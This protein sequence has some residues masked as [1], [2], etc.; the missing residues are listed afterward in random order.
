M[1]RNFLAVLFCFCTS[2]AAAK[3]DTEFLK[4]DLLL[5]DMRLKNQRIQDGGKSQ[6]LMSGIFFATPAWQEKFRPFLDLRGHFLKSGQ[7]ATN[8]GFGFRHLIFN[9]RIAF[10]GNVFYDGRQTSP[11]ALGLERFFLN[12]VG[13]G[14]EMIGKFFHFRA[15]GYWPLNN[16]PFEKLPVDAYV[17]GLIGV[18]IPAT[19][20]NIGLGSYY[21]F[22]FENIFG[23][24][25]KLSTRSYKGFSV[26]LS[27]TY[28]NFFRMLFESRLTWKMPIGGKQLDRLKALRKERYAKKSAA[29]PEYLKKLERAVERNEIIHVSANPVILQ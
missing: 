28:D 8:A 16:N 24:K 17:D 25:A 2:W 11:Q 27:A 15:N 9:D 1:L 22:N 7:F 18:E 6:G 10:G 12:Q 20:I 3:E 29:K 26:D 23:G 14:L 4:K 5:T 21:L 19:F 13:A